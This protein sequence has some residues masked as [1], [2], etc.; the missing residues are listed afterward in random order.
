MNG[1]IGISKFIVI[2]T[3][4]KHLRRLQLD[5]AVTT[6]ERVTSPVLHAEEEAQANLAK[7]QQIEAQARDTMLRMEKNP[8]VRF[9][10]YESPARRRLGLMRQS[11]AS[12][13][14]ARTLAKE[15]ARLARG[16][17]VR[18]RACLVTNPSPAP[19]NIWA[20]PS[21]RPN[22]RRFVTR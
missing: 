9:F 6:A 15:R 20:S 2:E 5:R 10:G 3:R 17:G 21:R 8:G 13:E 16:E 19:S 11:M 4:L 1:A 12:H 7:R 22:R 18:A 14:Q